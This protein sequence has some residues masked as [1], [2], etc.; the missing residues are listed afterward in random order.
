MNKTLDEII[1]KHFPDGIPSKLNSFVNEL[2]KA[3]NHADKEKNQLQEKNF[4]HS[5]FNLPLIGIAIT[6]SHYRWVA[7]NDKLSSLLGYDKEELIELG[8]DEIAVEEDREFHEKQLLK[9]VA[10]GEMDGTT[11]EKRYKKKNGQILY[12]SITSSCSRK[13]TGEVDYFISIIEDI[14]YKIKIE[15]QL[16]K[17]MKKLEN[18]NV[19]L[20]KKVKEEVEKSRTKDLMLAQQSKHTAIGEMIGNIAHQWRQPLNAVGLIIQNL[21]DAYEY[22][23]LNAEY[24][25]QKVQKSMELITFMSNTIDDFRNFFRMDKSKEKFNIKD[26]VLKA[27]SFVEAS[28]SNHNIK[29]HAEKLEDITVHGYPNGYAQVVLN[30]LN[31]AKDALLDSNQKNPQIDI[32]LKS[33]NNLSVL[34]ISDN[35]KGIPKEKAGKIFEPYFT[36]KSTGQGTGVGLY[37]SKSI[38]E[39][40]MNGKLY[41]DS[42]EEKTTFVIEL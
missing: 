12:V 39:Q 27:I 42:N 3:F 5:F 4:F 29:I 21:E 31:N 13:S 16:E 41:L 37:M 10:S 35:G 8:W 15:N 38:I 9:K 23:E 22:D 34:K 17:M 33:N 30:L 25:R 28:F 18:M 24:L 26:I 11:I 20:E 7:I 1:A 2:N 6:D 32:E 19:E 36:T 40:N 14:T